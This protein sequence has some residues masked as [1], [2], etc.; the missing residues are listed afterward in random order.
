MKK[1]IFS[2]KQERLCALL[3]EARNRAGFTQAELASKLQR[4]QSYVSKYESGERRLDVIEFI[5]ITRVLGIP[6]DSFLKKLS[7]TKWVAK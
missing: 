5:E 4:P 7:T 2:E 3:V 6:A 1:S